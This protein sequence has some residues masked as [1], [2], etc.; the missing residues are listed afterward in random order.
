MNVYLFTTQLPQECMRQK[1]L[2]P[3]GQAAPL[4]TSQFARTVQQ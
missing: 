4:G 1:K 2:F 3:I